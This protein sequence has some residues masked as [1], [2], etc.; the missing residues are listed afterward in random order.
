MLW[1]IILFLGAL[2]KKDMSTTWYLQ[3][4]INITTVQAR[5]HS[6]WISF[7]WIQTNHNWSFV[8]WNFWNDQQKRVRKKRGWFLVLGA[9]VDKQKSVSIKFMFDCC[10]IIYAPNLLC[11][12]YAETEDLMNHSLFYFYITLMVLNSFL[13]KF[14]QLL[15]PLHMPSVK[16]DWDQA[17]PIFHAHTKMCVL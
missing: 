12:S 15:L 6:T 4:I 17:P 7:P 3:A 2:Q 14:L 13:M 16:L 10:V 8:K 9:K 5:Y 11:L 1:N